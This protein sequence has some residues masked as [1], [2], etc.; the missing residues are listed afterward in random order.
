MLALLFNI[1]YQL[2]V[3]G[4]QQCEMQSMKPKKKCSAIEDIQF[5]Q[6]LV[7]L[8]NQH[9]LHPIILTTPSN[10]FAGVVLVLNLCTLHLIIV[11]LQPIHQTT[12]TTS[13]ERSDIALR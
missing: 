6:F 10:V 3:Q 9:S 13:I 11:S 4:P 12:S 8:Q 1:Q 2:I 7:S 5:Q